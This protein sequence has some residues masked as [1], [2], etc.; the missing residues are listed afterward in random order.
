M[1]ALH[2]SLILFSAS[3]TGRG[4]STKDKVFYREC[5]THS[6]GDQIEKMCFCSFLLCNGG[7]SSSV[8]PSSVLL[9]AA[10]AALVAAAAGGATSETTHRWRRLQPRPDH[11][12][13]QCQ[14]DQTTSSNHC[15][16]GK[17]HL[18][19]PPMPFLVQVLC[20]GDDAW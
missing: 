7:A 18:F 14:Q 20:S 6:Y 10:A 4:C 12:T 9:V 2:R 1:K 11:Q 15:E 3:V 16:D 8:Q 19:I 5:E 17:N 13:K